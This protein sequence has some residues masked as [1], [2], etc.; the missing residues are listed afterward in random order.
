MLKR[1]GFAIAA[2]FLLSVGTAGAQ[3]PSVAVSSPTAVRSGGPTTLQV[4]GFRHLD[5]V[6]VQIAPAETSPGNCCGITVHGAWRTNSHGDAVIRFVWPGYYL[7][8]AG[9]SSCTR[10]YWIP[11][12]TAIVTVSDQPKR[13]MPSVATTTVFVRG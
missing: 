7:S 13:Q 12:S 1:L 6:R 10:T 5:L 3:V 11:N 4:R 2:A 9:A 8:C